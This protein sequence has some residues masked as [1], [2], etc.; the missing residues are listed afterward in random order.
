[1]NDCVVSF[2]E[3]EFLHAIP[4][5]DIIVRFQNMADRTRRVKLQ[6]VTAIVNSFFCSNYVIVT[7]V[8]V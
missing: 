4:N 5:D 8:H 1:M 3:Q 6:V 7:F 2:V